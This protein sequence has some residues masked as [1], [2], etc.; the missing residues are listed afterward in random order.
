MQAP[1]NEDPVWK[2]KHRQV[3]VRHC[4]L[5]G[6]EGVGVKTPEKERISNSA[7]T[8]KQSLLNKIFFTSLRLKE[9]VVGN[10]PV[11]ENIYLFILEAKA[12]FF[13]FAHSFSAITSRICIKN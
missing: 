11:V 2:N 8:N 6:L 5:V 13:Q 10:T 12:A 3:L 9:R 1:V 4:N 7:V